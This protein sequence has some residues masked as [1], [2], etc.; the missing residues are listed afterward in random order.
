MANYVLLYSGGGMPETEAEQAA[1]MKIMKAWEAWFS[2][3][4]VSWA[5]LW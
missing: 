3:L 2:E 1:A 4:A 5:R